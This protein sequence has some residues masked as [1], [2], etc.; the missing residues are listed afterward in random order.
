MTRLHFSK[1][2]LRRQQHHLQQ[3]ERFLP[4]LI[5]KKRVLQQELVKVKRCLLE[6]EKEVELEKDEMKLWSG[7]LTTV[8]HEV[9]VL[10]KPTKVRISK[11]S[12]TSAILPE[13]EEVEFFKRRVDV[14][15]DPLWYDFGIPML[16]SLIVSCIKVDIL[17]KQIEI[18]NQELRVTAQRINLFEKIKIPACIENIRRIK[19]FLQDQQI[20]AVGIAKMAKKKIK[21]AS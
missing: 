18:L 14:L 2:E 1:N 10:F 12:L 3:Y 21:E 11:R 20:A 4:S 7:L 8:N 15:K 19:I 17:K 5:F 9:E 16:R 6:I 13:F